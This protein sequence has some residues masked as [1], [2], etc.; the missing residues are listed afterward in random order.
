[1]ENTKLLAEIKNILIKLQNVRSMM[2]KGEFIIADEKLSGIYTKI[3][4]IGLAAQKEIESCK[5]SEPQ[6]SSK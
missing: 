2:R 3:E 6:P 1:M 5:L 4:N